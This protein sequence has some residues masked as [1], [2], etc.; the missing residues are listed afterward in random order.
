MVQELLQRIMSLIWPKWLHTL[1]ELFPEAAVGVL[2][3]SCRVI[4][5]HPKFCQKVPCERVTVS[6]SE[7]ARVQLHLLVDVEMKQVV[8]LAFIWRR[9]WDTVATNECSLGNAT[10]L[11]LR[12]HNLYGIVF[13]EEVDLTLSDSVRLRLSL[14]YSL[15]EV[16]I[17]AQ[18]LFVKGYP[19]W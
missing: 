1:C 15:L 14:R 12:L 19:W 7:C 3:Y 16:C 8:E 18:N 17:K 2:R 5:M 6:H 10:V 13:Q 11:V 9:Q 4:Y